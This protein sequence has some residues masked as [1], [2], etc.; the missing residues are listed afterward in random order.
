MLFKYQMKMLVFCLSPRGTLNSA[1]PEGFISDGPGS[2][3]LASFMKF[4][5]SELTF[6]FFSGKALSGQHGR[7]WKVYSVLNSQLLCVPLQLGYVFPQSHISDCWGGLFL[8]ECGLQEMLSAEVNTANKQTKTHNSF[9]LWT[10]PR[11]SLWHFTDDFSG[12]QS[13]SLSYVLSLL[14]PKY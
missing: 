12:G 11:V 4:P 5:F 6:F 3:A 10:L 13:Y 7:G 2:Q 9:A 1:S 8:N 14:V